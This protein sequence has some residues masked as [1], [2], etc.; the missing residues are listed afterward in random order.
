M[1]YTV[2]VTET[3]EAE[4]DAAYRWLRDQYSPEYAVRWREGLVEAIGGLEAFPERCALA[5]EARFFRRKIRQLLYGKRHGVYRLLFE[6]QK[7]TVYLLHVRHA[8]RRHL[9][10]A[11]QPEDDE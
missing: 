5:P 11:A 1:K 4:L 10:P 6:I 8:A 9:S 2:E 3:A 7:R